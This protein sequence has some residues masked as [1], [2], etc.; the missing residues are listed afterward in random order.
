MLRPA[1]IALAVLV[2][3]DFLMFGGTYTHTVGRLAHAFLN[4]NR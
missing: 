1:V 4:L 3:I 2:S